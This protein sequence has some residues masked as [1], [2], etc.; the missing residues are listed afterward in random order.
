MAS[1]QLIQGLAVEL[2]KPQGILI[3]RAVIAEQLQTAIKSGN[4]AEITRL[5]KLNELANVEDKPEKVKEETT[6]AT[7]PKAA[8]AKADTPKK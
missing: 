8:T 2:G 1:R 5:A 6:A 4:V 7:A 3:A